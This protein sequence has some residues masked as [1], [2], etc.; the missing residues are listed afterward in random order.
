MDSK[1][2]ARI[3]S[4]VALTLLVPLIGALG[5]PV[6]PAM[7]PRAPL[8][9]GSAGA[10][11]RTVQDPFEGQSTPDAPH[12][13]LT[14]VSTP[15][16]SCSSYR[17]YGSTE[18]AYDAQDTSNWV[19]T[20]P[21]CVDVIGV[22]NYSAWSVVSVGSRP[23]GV[24]VDNTTGDVFVTD[25]GGDHV[26]VIGSANRT[27]FASIRVGNEPKGLSYDWRTGE[28]YVANE[29][30]DSV[31][32]ISGAN[33]TVVGRVRVGAE[34]LG[35]VADPQSGTVFVADH[36]ASTVTAFSAST[37]SVIATVP[38][39][40]HPYD[41]AMDNLTDQA[42]V[43]NEGSNTLSVINASTRTVAAKIPVLAPFSDLQGIAYDAASRQ[44]WVGAGLFWVLIV[45]AANDTVAGWSS[46][47]PSGVD[48][49][50]S[51]GDI[52]FTNSG[53]ATYA[54]ARFPSRTL[55]TT[56]LTFVETGLPAGTSWGI[57]IGSVSSRSN[58]SRIG[59]GV[60][61]WAGVYYGSY[62]WT[63][64]AP[65]GYSATPSSGS[66]NYYNGAP[67]RVSLVFARTHPTPVDFHE[68][69]LSPGATWYVNVT[70]ASTGAVVAALSGTTPWLNTSL[71]IG[72]YSYTV[73]SP[74]YLSSAVHPSAGTAVVGLTTL[75]E[76]VRFS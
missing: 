75:R 16:G 46:S 56:P 43:T 41:I 61:V 3:G 55:A 35:I 38:V 36:G 76:R 69:G 1:A 44:M 9:P 23:F 67:S 74:G 57:H 37:L 48:Y 25:S 62:S 53:N 59:F 5:S 7:A 63:A 29:G 30:S 26:S 19:A 15:A 33:L 60:V 65:R 18:L 39:G 13:L 31:S 10:A 8:A 71:A 40:H 51:N 47:D 54:C 34:P 4:L 66:L 11:P 14:T 32:V 58:G 70:N 49:V 68:R 50:P 52:C 73:Q 24:A 22:A 28:I 2:R 42:F 12:F 27:P 17:Y 64:L 45:N 72:N 6:A 21:S 20:P